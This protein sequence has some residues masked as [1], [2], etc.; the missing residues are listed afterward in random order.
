M[1]LGICKEFVH[2]PKLNDP[3]VLKILVQYHNNCAVAWNGM[4]ETIR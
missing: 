1:K 3:K 4:H 2:D